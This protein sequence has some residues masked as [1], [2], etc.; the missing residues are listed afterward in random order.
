MQVDTSK[1]NKEL[2]ALNPDA[3]AFLKEVFNRLDEDSSGEVTKNALE[4]ALNELY[5]SETAAGLTKLLPNEMKITQE[6][7]ATVSSSSWFRATLTHTA[8]STRA[9]P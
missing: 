5:D 4:N 1:K 3:E 7:L 8:T 6:Q 9:Y 2:L